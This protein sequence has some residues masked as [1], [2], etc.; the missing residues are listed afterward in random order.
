[1]AKHYITGDTY[2]VKNQLKSLG[3]KWDADRRQWYALSEEAAKKAQALVVPKFYNSP[4]PVDLGTTDP[5]ALA[6]RFGR[7]AV[8]GATVQ[9]FA[10]YGLPKGVEP[11]PDGTVRVMRGV[12]YV[13]VAHTTRRYLS[14]EML[15]DFD[16]FGKEPGGS[17]QWDGVPV[18]PTA[19]EAAE[20][21]Q[22]LAEAQAK[23]KAAREAAEAEAIAAKAAWQCWEAEIAGLERCS[24]DPAATSPGERVIRLPE[25]ESK[26]A[27]RCEE[28]VLPDG[29]KGWRYTPHE[30]NAPYYYLPTDAASA[31]RSDH[32]IKWG[33]TRDQAREWLAKYSGCV[34]DDVY[35]QIAECSDELA[36]DLDRAAAEKAA[37]EAAEKAARAL[38]NTMRRAICAEVAR[39]VGTAISQVDVIDMPTETAPARARVRGAKS[40]AVTTARVTSDTD[41]FPSFDV[42]IE[43]G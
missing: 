29:R 42:L 43:I 17:Y 8:A 35:R 38:R 9:S 25:C 36:A 37:R 11:A 12:R 1:M 39:S 14:R 6:E 2:A 18:E 16:L 27:A 20:E 30:S 3:C 23:A 13:Q 15:E 24:V 41:A 28:I 40:L 26:W 19:A 31:V 10:V 34:G 7:V 5:V 33:I 32:A 4:P 22:K 21:A